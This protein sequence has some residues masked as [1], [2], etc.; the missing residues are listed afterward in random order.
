[1]LICV[2]MGQL[3]TSFHASPKPKVKRFTTAKAP[4]NATINVEELM[5]PSEDENEEEEEE[6]EWRPLKNEKGRRVSKKPKATGVSS[7]AP[8]WPQTTMHSCNFPS[9]ADAAVTRVVLPSFF[10]VF[11]Q[12]SLHQ[13]AVQVPKREDDVRREL[14]VRSREM[15]KHGQLGS[16]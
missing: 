11:V 5:S 7:E 13:Q 3:L 15:S 12:R 14:P 2:E 1:M 6:D 9:D 16:V 10:P 8:C 4:Q